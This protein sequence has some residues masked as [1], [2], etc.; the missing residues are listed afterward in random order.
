[1]AACL[2]L[3]VAV[4]SWL[5]LVDSQGYL[6]GSTQP[7][8]GGEGIGAVASAIK[9][10]VRAW[11]IAVLCRTVVRCAVLLYSSHFGFVDCTFIRPYRRA[12]T[13]ID[14]HVYYYLGAH[15]YH[16]CMQVSC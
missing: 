9:L 11:T 8:A 4:A 6:T 3:W 7:H 5:L 13:F 15:C 10:L 2:S 12:L 16:C 14:K 1:M